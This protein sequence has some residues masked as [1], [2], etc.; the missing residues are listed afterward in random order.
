MNVACEYIGSIRSDSAV[1]NLVARF[2]RDK[3]WGTGNTV[4]QGLQGNAAGAQ[5][6]LD[7]IMK[8]NFLGGTSLEV[9]E[10]ELTVRQSIS[11]LITDP[12]VLL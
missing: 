9:G 5:D 2:P 3:S 6:A 8:C 10:V 7:R 12:V 11:R 1:E 4:D